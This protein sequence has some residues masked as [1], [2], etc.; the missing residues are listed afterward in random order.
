M[1]IRLASECD[2]PMVLCCLKVFGNPT[3]R[4]FAFEHRT[5]VAEHRG[6][7]VGTARLDFVLRLVKG[8]EARIEDVAVLPEF[9]RQGIGTEL[10]KF[11]AKEAKRLG[12]YKVQLTCAPKLEGWYSKL[13]FRR[14][15]VN[16]RI[17]L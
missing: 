2:M 13:G 12:C 9:S 7:V 5:Y 10:V 11:L 14:H 3:A 4:K 16:M 15:E 17:D 1:N 6:L 8:S